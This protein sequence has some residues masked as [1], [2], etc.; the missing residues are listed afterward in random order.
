MSSHRRAVGQ[1]PEI[2]AVVR[3]PNLHLEFARDLQAAMEQAA[4]EA[5]EEAALSVYYAA[6]KAFYEEQSLRRLHGMR[7]L[8]R[9]L[10]RHMEV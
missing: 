5:A 8:K 3:L 6:L 2:I 7:P 9:V 4:A 10:P 1:K